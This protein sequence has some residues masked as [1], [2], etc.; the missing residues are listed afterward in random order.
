M[1]KS[2]DAL[3]EQKEA[4]QERLKAVQDAIRQKEAAKAAREAS[5]A[6][7][8]RTH[9]LILAGTLFEALIKYGKI[10][11]E[12][13]AEAAATYYGNQIKQAQGQQP[14]K[15]EAP[16]KCAER[17]KKQVKKLERDRDLLVSTLKAL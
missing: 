13:T 5:Q 11:A 4:L 10:P 17:I 7:K 14:K 9:V 16:E 3:K 1:K 6:R 2:L 12:Q 8:T 15:G